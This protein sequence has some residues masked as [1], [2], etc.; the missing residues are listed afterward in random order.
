MAGKDYAL[1][2]ETFALSVD[3]ISVD[4]ETC[5]NLMKCGQRGVSVTL[6]Y[7]RSLEAHPGGLG[8]RSGALQ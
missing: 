8:F 2:K 1:L 7:L 3:E 6:D 5:W 4:P